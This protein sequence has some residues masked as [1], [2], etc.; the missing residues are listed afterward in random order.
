MSFQVRRSRH[1]CYGL[2]TPG[3]TVVASCYLATFRISCK[4]WLASVWVV[5]RRL[6]CSSLHLRQYQHRRS[7]MVPSEGSFSLDLNARTCLPSRTNASVSGS[8]FERSS[9]KGLKSGTQ[10]TRSFPPFAATS[11]CGTIRSRRLLSRRS[12]CEYS[13]AFET[14]TATTVQSAW[15]FRDRRSCA[16][17]AERLRLLYVSWRV[18]T[19]ASWGSRTMLTP[20]S[21]FTPEYVGFWL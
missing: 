6:S 19:F 3:S 7:A 10:N 17:G 2:A 18:K 1:Q 11:R 13:F 21:S 8:V 15:V 5:M 20:S 4:N 9:G 12:N 14:I 16:S